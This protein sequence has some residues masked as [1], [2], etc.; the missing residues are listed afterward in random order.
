MPEGIQHHIDF[1]T[2]T[3]HFDAKVQTPKKRRAL[4]EDEIAIAKRQTSATG[5]NIQPGI[6][7]TIGSPG[8]KS[9]PRNGGNASLGTVINELKNCDVSIVPQCLCALYV[10]PDDGFPTNASSMS[11]HFTRLQLAITDTRF[12]DSFGIVEY[13][14]LAY[15]PSDLDMFFAK[16]SPSLV[17]M[18]PTLDSIDGE[19][20]QTEAESMGNN[21]EPVISLKTLTV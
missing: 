12:L 16:F 8:G 14:P 4:N 7:H 2:P 1:V 17:G 11:D 13:T 19:F 20:L 3:V 5:H 10:L 9:L 6:A 18:R 15:L 21:S